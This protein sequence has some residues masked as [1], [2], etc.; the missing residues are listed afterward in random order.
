MSSQGYGFSSSHVWMWE[1]DYKESWAPKNWCFWTAVLEKT[2]ESPMGC[3]EIQLVHPKGNQSWIFIGRTDAEAETAILWPHDAKKWLLEKTLMLGG[4]GGRRRRGWQRMKG[5]DGITDW[6]DMS[7]ANLWD[8]V[9]DQEGWLAAVHGVAK[10]QTW[11]SDWTDS[12][13][14]NLNYIPPSLERLKI[15]FCVYCLFWFPLLWIVHLLFQAE[16]LDLFLVLFTK[17][18]KVTLV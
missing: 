18:K 2:L 1:L 11:L 4:I 15:F 12:D 3:K 13:R 14:Y 8:L 5:L 6:M 7:L 17:E 9:M 10:S 16:S